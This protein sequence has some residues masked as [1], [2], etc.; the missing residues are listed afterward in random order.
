M[1]KMFDVIFIIHIEVLMWNMFNITT[2]TGE[3]L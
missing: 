2:N 1:K 3:E